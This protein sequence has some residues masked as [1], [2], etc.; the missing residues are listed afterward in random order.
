MYNVTAI[1]SENKDLKLLL[2]QADREIKDLKDKVRSKDAE[3]AEQLDCV[4][5][6]VHKAFSEIDMLCTYSLLPSVSQGLDSGNNHINK[7]FLLQVKCSNNFI[8][9]HMLSSLSWRN[10]HNNNWKQKFSICP[11]PLEIKKN[12]WKAVVKSSNKHSETVEIV[13]KC[14]IVRQDKARYL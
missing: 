8:M 3:T 5:S 4:F 10:W 1:G 9:L 11:L 13:Y 12:P 2:S 7:T 6:K 14:C